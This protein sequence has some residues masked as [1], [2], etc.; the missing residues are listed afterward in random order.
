MT[1]VHI[2]AF[3]SGAGIRVRLHRDTDDQA[4][5]G[6]SFDQRGGDDHG[7]L[8]VSGHLGL[9]GHALDRTGADLADAVACPDDDHAGPEGTA[10]VDQRECWPLLPRPVLQ[11]LPA[12]KAGAAKRQHTMPRPTLQSSRACSLDD[13]SFHERTRPASRGYQPESVLVNRHA[14]KQG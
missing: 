10:Q 9:A 8:D 14:D 6:G 12:A 5:E 11:R 7:G 3:P 1:R 4:E 2:G 13:Y